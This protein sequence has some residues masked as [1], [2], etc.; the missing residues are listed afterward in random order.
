MLLF[1]LLLCFPNDVIFDFLRLFF[2]YCVI[3]VLSGIQLAV[4][5]S[6]PVRF[7]QGLLKLFN[8]TFCHRPIRVVCKTSLLIISSD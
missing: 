3:T 5:V 1:M 2:I 4:Y 8:Y 6:L 7:Q